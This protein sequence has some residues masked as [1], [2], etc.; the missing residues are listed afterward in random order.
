MHLHGVENSHLEVVKDANRH[1]MEEVRIWEVAH[2]IGNMSKHVE[3]SVNMARREFGIGSL[4]VGI[5]M[6]SI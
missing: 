6:H 5:A 2:E 4:G 1:S 3:T